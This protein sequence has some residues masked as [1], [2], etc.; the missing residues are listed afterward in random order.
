ME[1]NNGWKIV[2]AEI[3]IGL[4]GFVLLLLFT[5]PIPLY[6]S[7]TFS[8]ALLWLLAASVYIIDSNRAFWVN[9]VRIQAETFAVRKL[10]GRPFDVV[11]AG[12]P[13][14][15]RGVAE[16]II[17]PTKVVQREYPTTQENIFRDEGLVPDGKKAPFRVTFGVSLKDEAEARRVLG[18]HYEVT[19]PDGTT[20]RFNHVVP[21]DG[22]SDAR[23]TA[24]V[25][26]IIRFRI[27]NP[28]SFVVNIG[29]IADADVQLEDEVTTIINNFYPLFSAAQA[30][31][32]LEWM[33][34]IL[35]AAI[36]DRIEVVRTP[37]I[38]R[39]HSDA[40]GIDLVG[41]AISKIL[42]TK[43]QN[44]ALS[45][46]VKATFEGEATVRKATRDAEAAVITGN[47]AAAAAGALVEK[48]LAG[49]GEGLKAAALSS[50]VSAGELLGADVG[51]AVGAGDGTFILG[52]DGIAQLAGLV[53]AFSPK[54][55]PK[56]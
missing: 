24:E 42:F 12:P 2:V 51:K 14:A 11:D 34:V 16:F 31:Q 33:N 38:T 26:P 9:S 53:K 35:F 13:V 30:L 50:G 5:N 52:A 17:L 15:P 8:W 56:P 23:V 47:A 36:E 43:N 27:F 21:D 48:T 6:G 18:D 37:G 44:E 25:V 29:M 7:E 19:R 28:I 4:L 32:N 45:A 41:A 49:Q 40:W 22:L 10:F 54:T 39:G 55:P 1:M 3:L 20:I 46:V